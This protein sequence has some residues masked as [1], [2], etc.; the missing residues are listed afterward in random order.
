M[1]MPALTGVLML[2][3]ALGVMSGP[4]EAQ[5][6][7]YAEN[8]GDDFN[9]L[10]SMGG[11][12]LLLAIKFAAPNDMTV[13]SMEV[14]TG[15]QMGTNTLG[16][17][18]HNAVLNR[19]E[20]VLSFGMWDMDSMNSWQGPPLP[21]CVSLSSGQIYWVVWG[22]QNF[23]QAS[24]DLP[25]AT[26]GQEYRG[27]FDGGMSWSGPFQSN[28]DHWKFRLYC[29]DDETQFSRGDCNTD[30]LFNIADAIFLLNQLFGA[31]P[32]DAICDDAC[33]AN[34]DRMKDIA[35]GIYM[36]SALFAMGEEPPAPYPGC[37]LADNP[38]PIGCESFPPC[39]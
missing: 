27:S 12:S 17:W 30:T 33:D 8:G 14:F 34:G 25:M 20:V 1:R 5:A 2:T 23:S 29:D 24:V 7:C 37:G 18:S 31:D 39:E 3:L 15:E 22:P 16:I 11:P 36:L 35:D 10:V 26:L 21:S 28:D 38:T 4:L 9:D 13:T 19:P 6:P 32:P